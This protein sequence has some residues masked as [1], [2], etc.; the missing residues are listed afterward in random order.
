MAL[1]ISVETHDVAQ[2]SEEILAILEQSIAAQHA[3]GENHFCATLRGDSGRIEGGITARA[4]WGWLYIATLAIEPL[5]QGQGYG[6]ELLDAA[7][8]WGIEHGCRN[9]YLMTM[10]FQAQAFYESAG[11]VIFAELPDFPGDERR[12]F[13]RKALMP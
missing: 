12:L 8:R 3:R 7:E 4:F 9:A 6:R 11:Y 5:L 13:M 1:R 10:T 2:A